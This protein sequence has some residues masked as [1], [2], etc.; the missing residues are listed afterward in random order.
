MRGYYVSL[1]C[2]VDCM[3]NNLFEEDRQLLSRGTAILSG[4]SAIGK[5]ENR[6]FDSVCEMWAR[7]QRIFRFREGPI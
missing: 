4:L 7:L 6:H 2:Q 1:A 3:R 5:L